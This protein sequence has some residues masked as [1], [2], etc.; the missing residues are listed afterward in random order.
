MAVGAKGS[1]RF[2]VDLSKREYCVPKQEFHLEGHVIY[3][4]SP[5]MI[6]AEKLRALC[7][8]MPEYQHSRAHTGGTDGR[9]ARDF[10]DIALIMRHE[11]SL[12]WGDDACRS[13]LRQVF[14]AKHVDLA[15]LGR[16]PSDTVRA[17]H[18][19]DFRAVRDTVPP[20]SIV[21]DFGHYF[22]V[23][24]AMVGKLEAFWEVETPLG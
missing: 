17:F 11:S 6:V 16:V 18:E 5:L 24:A 15:L 19:D 4:Y 7:Q 21:H 23:V 10:Y 14:Q 9:R 20:G 13:L 2:K 1:T 3:V 12:E 22:D 8:K